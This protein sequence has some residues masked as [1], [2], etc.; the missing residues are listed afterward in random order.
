MKVIAVYSTKGGAGKTSAAVNL[1]SEASKSGA[2][3]LWDLDAQGASTYLAGVKPKLKGGVA[4]LLKGSNSISDVARKSAFPR[5]DGSHRIDVVP[6]DDSYRELELMLDA[7]K[8]SRRRLQK[9]LKD[10]SGTYDTVILDC[11]PGA[12]LVAE[13]AVRS[14]DVIVTP[15]PPAALSL[16]SLEQVRDIV[17][18]SAK[19]A[20]ILAFLSM[21]DRRKLTHRRAVED[22]PAEHSEIVDVVVPASVVVERMGAERAPVAAF[23]PRHQVTEAYTQLWKLVAQHA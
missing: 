16:R 9:V 21:V 4:K 13:N 8:G 6:A 20:P 23:A 19:P 22:L 15:V 18:D 17:A 12:S 1:A 3:L 11:P 7:A 2:V 10:A 14:A 5:A